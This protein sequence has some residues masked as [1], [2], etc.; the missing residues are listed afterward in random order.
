MYIHELRAV[1]VLNKALTRLSEAHT[2][3]PKAV[4][5]PDCDGGVNVGVAPSE[6]A[7]EAL[8]SGTWISG[9]SVLLVAAISAG[10]D[11]SGDFIFFAIL[12]LII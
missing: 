11:F 6:V 9:I 7:V 2:A 4:I 8:L 1:W 5:S 12:I 10:S 3:V